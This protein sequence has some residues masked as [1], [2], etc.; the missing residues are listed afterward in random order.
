VTLVVSRSS[1]RALLAGTFVAALAVVAGAAALASAAERSPAPQEIVI[2]IRYSHFIPAH[3]TVA[4]GLPVRIRL[5]NEDPIDH[6]WI[7]GDAAMHAFH[8]TSTEQVHPNVPTEVAVPAMS[9]RTTT[10][11]FDAP[12]DLAYICH[13]PGHEAY[14][15]VGWVTIEPAN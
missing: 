4:L 6:E 2:E 5:R 12:G 14:G 7:V 13:L 15:M 1:A 9:E 11:T 10:I 3:I 8:R